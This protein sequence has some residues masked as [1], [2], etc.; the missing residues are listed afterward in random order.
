M[1]HAATG[2]TLLWTL[3]VLVAAGDHHEKFYSSSHY[4]Q[5]RYKHADFSVSAWPRGHKTL[6]TD[7]ITH[8]FNQFSKLQRH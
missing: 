4:P 1:A 8:V 5:K 6:L 2:L 3:C 7:W